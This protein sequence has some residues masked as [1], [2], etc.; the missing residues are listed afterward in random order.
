MAARIVLPVMED[1]RP[2]RNRARRRPRPFL[3]LLIIAASI[4]GLYSFGY[5]TSFRGALPSPHFE[6]VPVSETS[7]AGNIAQDVQ[8]ATKD[9]VPLEAHII[10]KCPDTRD[11]LKEL[12]LPAMIQVYQKV[13]FTLTYIGTPTENDG[14]E[15][16]HGPGE[17]M[18]NIIELCAH[19]LYP[20]PK[21][22]LGFTMCLTKDYSSI[23]ER[24]LVEDCALEH[25]V[26]FDK[27]N[28]CATRDDGAFGM[29]MLRESVKR[30][31]SVCFLSTPRLAST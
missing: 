4:Y 11:C 30:S 24:E 9:L 16:K 15:C 6:S 20:D 10:S 27:I 18:G 8:L 25:A 29:S 21:I 28:E 12:L 1:K 14:V 5:F 2:V 26:D 7:G 17:C 22:W 31:A 13:N 19:Q 3:L 23:P